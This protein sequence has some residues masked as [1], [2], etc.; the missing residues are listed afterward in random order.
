[1]V[2]NKGLFLRFYIGKW[3]KRGWLE[4]KGPVN[5]CGERPGTYPTIHRVIY[6]VNFVQRILLAPPKIGANRK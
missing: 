6:P 5:Y 1:M 2:Y 3:V 4:K